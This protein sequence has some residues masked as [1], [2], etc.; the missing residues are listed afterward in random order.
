MDARAIPAAVPS[1][2]RAI[3]LARAN[4]ALSELG[5]GSRGLDRVLEI[6]REKDAPLTAEL[7][8]NSYS[9]PTQLTHSPS[10]LPCDNAKEVNHQTCESGPLSRPSLSPR[11]WPAVARRSLTRLRPPPR[12]PRRA[13]R[14]HRRPR[15]RRRRAARITARTWARAQAQ[16]R[17]AEARSRRP[18]AR[19]RTYNPRSPLRSIR[20]VPTTPGGRPVS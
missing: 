6:A 13:R 10:N 11:R 19:R 7:P 20:P 9:A 3:V 2:A 8:S 18:P 4:A 12:R 5:A 16:A 1:P 17:R 15:R 14:P